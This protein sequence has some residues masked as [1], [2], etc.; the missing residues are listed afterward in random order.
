MTVYVDMDGVLADFDTGY[1][2]LFGHAPMGES[3]TDPNVIKLVGTDFF[4]TLPKYDSADALIQLV[5]EHAGQYSIATAPLRG[6]NKNSGHWKRQWLAQHLSPAPEQIKVNGQKEVYAVSKEGVPNVL[7]DD[8]PKNIQR[9]RD[10]G[11]IGIEYYAP[12]DDLA[13]VAQGLR[14]ALDKIKKKSSNK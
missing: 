4:N 13:I 8:K 7:I 2:R 10:A 5:L 14:Q 12:R 1:E 9:W 3:K 11:G 6:D